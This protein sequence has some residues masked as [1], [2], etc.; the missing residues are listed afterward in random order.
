LV[1]DEKRHL[2]RGLVLL[3]DLLDSAEKHRRVAVWQGHL[4]ELLA[5][6]G[7]VTGFA[8]QENESRRLG[9]S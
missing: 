9:R 4:E 7:G 3:D 6:A 2:E 5:A 8:E 1:E